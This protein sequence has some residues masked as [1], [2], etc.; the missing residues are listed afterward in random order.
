MVQHD[1]LDASFAALSDPTRRGILERLGRGPATVSE[2]AE[3]F[4]M[5]LTGV[6]KHLRLLEDAGMVVTEKR[7]RVRYCR[8]GDNRLDREAA[9]IR[10]YRQMVEA[11]MDRLERFL[12]HTEHNHEH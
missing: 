10:G 11:R 8:L 2:L 1:F 9:W 6:K 12:E 5:T 4:A 3:R 7:G